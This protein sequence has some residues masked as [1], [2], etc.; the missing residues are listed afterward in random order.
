M[1]TVDMN[2]V[3]DNI[4]ACRNALK[5]LENH[6]RPMAPSNSEERW[7]E[8]RDKMGES[9]R[10]FDAFDK[11]IRVDME[12][13]R[14]VER[15]LEEA[16]EKLKAWAGGSTVLY[17]TERGDL[18]VKLLYCKRVVAWLQ[19]HLGEVSEASDAIQTEVAKSVVHQ[20][21]R[22]TQMVHMCGMLSRLKALT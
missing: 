12:N 11:N 19:E 20:E 21:G 15:S 2:T 13:L 6:V 1:S 17:N 5:G 8:F 10:Y 3:V 16:D 4:K 9:V 7:A 14:R 18:A 22:M